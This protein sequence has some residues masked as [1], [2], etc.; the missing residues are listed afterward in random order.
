MINAK[1]LLKFFLVPQNIDHVYA[2][3]IKDLKLNETRN[4]GKKNIILDK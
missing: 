3:I 1:M 2:C 4:T